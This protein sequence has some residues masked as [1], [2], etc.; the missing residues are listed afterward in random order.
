MIVGMWNRDSTSV[1]HVIQPHHVSRVKHESSP[2]RSEMWVQY[3]SPQG[4]DRRANSCLSNRFLADL[5]SF[6]GANKNEAKLSFL[7]EKRS[8][9]RSDATGGFFLSHLLFVLIE[10]IPI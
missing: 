4:A 6:V 5:G 1:S 9:R 8:I 2:R 7:L 3:A 10:L